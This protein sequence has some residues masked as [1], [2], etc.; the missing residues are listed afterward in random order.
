VATF[1]Q[2]LFAAQQALTQAENNLKTLM[3]PNRADLMWSTALIPETRLDT[4]VTPPAL[5]D[6][7]KQALASRPELAENS[8]ALDVNG[9]DWRLAR[10][11]AK[12]Q[13]NAFANLTA[14][15][16]AGQMVATGPNPF[17]AFLPSGFGAVPPLLIGGYGQ[18]ISN[19][20]SGTFPSAQVGVQV[21]LPIRNRTAESRVAVSAAESR[22]L[23]AV[24]NQIAMAVEADV[25]N[26]LQAVNSSQARLEASA[27][28]RGSAEEQYASEQRQ[29]QAG[30]SSVF[31]VLQRQTDL[32][33]ARG[34]E[35]RAHA[36]LAEALA[37]LDRAT[38]RTIEARGIKL[39]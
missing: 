22:R 36:D 12:P 34:R 28:A 6:A 23:Q 38:A 30:T 25:R 8:L 18:S 9:L 17:S 5:E 16:L 19:L 31:L 7:V 15:G 24:Q 20:V 1:Q 27:L 35:V 3:L 26:S 10:E 32:I 4:N 21:S 2:D 13:V 11:A 37:N 29:F 14:A 33:A 39:N